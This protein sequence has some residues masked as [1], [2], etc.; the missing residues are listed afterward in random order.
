[1]EKVFAVVKADAELRQYFPEYG[2]K[3]F[4]D[5]QYLFDVVATL[6]HDDLKAQVLRGM[7]K[8]KRSEPGEGSIPV[9]NAMMQELENIPDSI[10]SSRGRA[11]QMMQRNSLQPQKEEEKKVEKPLPN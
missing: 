8:K 5:R 3:T 9:T 11:V 6:R 10:G 4:P 7:R 1:M 2:P